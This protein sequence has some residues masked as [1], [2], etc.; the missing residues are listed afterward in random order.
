MGIGRLIK[1]L[2]S[3]LF[4]TAFCY[5]LVVYFPDLYDAFKTKFMDKTVPGT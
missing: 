1:I 5:F 4:L 3:I 2:L